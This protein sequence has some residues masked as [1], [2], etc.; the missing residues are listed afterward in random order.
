MIA[1]PRHFPMLQ[2]ARLVLR[3]TVDADAAAI[4]AIFS[5]PAVTRH[6]NLQTFTDVDEARQLVQR[7]RERFETGHSIRWGIAL[8]DGAQLIGSC[9][10]IF[11]AE[12]AK[13]ELGYEIGS[14]YWNRGYAGEALRAVL[15]YAFA[16]LA[17]RQI[18]AHVMPGNDA[19]KHLLQKLG[20]VSEGMIEKAGFWNEQHHDLERFTLEP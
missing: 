9:G 18:V 4:H 16:T 8:E 2:T 10:L 13:A 12:H 11:D 19:S 20:F 14:A 5:D 3:E 6:Y 1:P 7:R 17:L 15:A